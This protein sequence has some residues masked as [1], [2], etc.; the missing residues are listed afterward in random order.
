MWLA[1]GG[2]PARASKP[3]LRVERVDH[4][5]CA[6]HGLVT[7]Y[8]IEVE[9]EGLLRRRRTSD[10][11]L[12]SQ[13]GKLLARRVE[14]GTTF[15]A[16]KRPLYISFVL[17]RTKTYAKAFPAIKKGLVDLVRESPRHSKFSLVSYDDQAKLVVASVDKQAITRAIEQL[18]LARETTDRSLVTALRVALGKTFQPP[19]GARALLVV[20][21]DGVD[22]FPEWD[23]FR[24]VGQ[25]ACRQ[26]APIYT[27]AY[28]PSDERG[29]LLNL[30]EISKRSRG[31]LRWAQRA[32]QIRGELANLQK[33]LGAMRLLT[34]RLPNRC[35]KEQSVKLSAGV[36]E[37]RPI[38]IAASR[39]TAERGDEK[40]GATTPNAEQRPPVRVVWLVVG[41][42]G[43]MVAIGLV[44]FFVLRGRRRLAG[45]GELPR[46]TALLRLAHED[47]GA[48]SLKDENGQ[49]RDGPTD[50]DDTGPASASE[51]LAARH[52]RGGSSRAE[53][54]DDGPATLQEAL[55]V[56][57]RRSAK[58]TGPLPLPEP[59]PPTPV[60]YGLWGVGFD[61]RVL[62][63]S[64]GARIGSDRRYCTVVVPVEWQT[65]AVHADLGLVD[66][67]LTIRD[68]KSGVVTLVNGKPVG[69]IVLLPGDVVQLGPV[70]RLQV[71]SSRS[72]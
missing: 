37:S 63:P 23:R 1:A 25:Q 51:A 65:A 35:Q 22:S 32:G 24:K 19:K 26:G 2:F 66:G 13:A 71:V 15:A 27:L 60:S 7:I 20:V 50:D 4:R 67:Q 17:Q 70:L 49:R 11:K 53:A 56:R 29:P 38:V 9:L 47:A 44:T 40:M 16:T 45:T 62:I 57:Q 52:R 69:Q 68:L 5:R 8:A 39:A 28:S 55:A 58:A 14:H 31:W 34:Y 61:Y 41:L 59:T 18:E 36:L 33:E 64:T 48:Q 12:F 42:S 46:P 72:T 6:E 10:Y 43:A 54:E 3:R 30:G 21:S